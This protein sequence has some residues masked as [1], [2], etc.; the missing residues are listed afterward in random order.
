MADTTA[1]GLNLHYPGLCANIL[2]NEHLTMKT[3]AY[4]PWLCESESCWN[5]ISWTYLS[6]F[7]LIS[8]MDKKQQRGQAVQFSSR[9]QYK[10]QC[11]LCGHE[12]CTK[13]KWENQSPFCIIWMLQTWIGYNPWQAIG[14]SNELWEI[15]IAA[16]RSEKSTLNS[17]ISV[18][19][20]LLPGCE[21][22]TALGKIS[23]GLQVVNSVDWQFL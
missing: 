4:K 1:V 22:V 11:D 7:F 8:Q 20:K 3:H 19:R 16:A 18:C 5:T 10:V 21:P 2:K 13:L 17:A 12:R 15:I 6:P 23:L 9:E 14:S